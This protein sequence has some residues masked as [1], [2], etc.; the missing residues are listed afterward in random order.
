[1]GSGQA[2]G[3]PLPPRSPGDFAFCPRIICAAGPG[4]G[5]LGEWEGLLPSLA[6]PLPRLRACLPR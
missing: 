2:L 1:M 3:I 6:L 4:A 5:A